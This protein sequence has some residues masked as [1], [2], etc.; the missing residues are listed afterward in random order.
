MIRRKKQII[1]AIMA[2]FFVLS[3][4]FTAVQPFQ[5]KSSIKLLVIQNFDKNIDPYAASRSNEYLSAILSKVAYSD[6][7]LSQ[8]LDSGFNIDK[9]YFPDD[10]NDRVKEWGKMIDVQPVE[11]TGIIDVSA[12]HTD[13]YQ[14]EQIVRAIGRVLIEKNGD[15]HGYGDSVSVKSIEG[16]VT[17]KWP[18]RPNLILNLA[19]A[20][21]LGLIAGLNYIYLFPE[22]HFSFKIALPIRKKRKLLPEGERTANLPES[23]FASDELDIEYENSGPVYEPDNNYVQ[24]LIKKNIINQEKIENENPTAGFEQ[25]LQQPERKDIRGNMG[26]ILG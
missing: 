8:V 26:N 12:Y 4:F 13:K 22:A 14:A 19:A 5:Y 9:Q 11:S 24:K 2:I 15:Y 17:S 7:F 16:P 6:S 25:V 23:I 21:V 3:L 10:I 20:L 1:I 18:A